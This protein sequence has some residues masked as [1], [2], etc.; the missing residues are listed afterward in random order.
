MTQADEWRNDDADGAGKQ[1]AV[2]EH[3][4]C[5]RQS[6]RCARYASSSS[7]VT[8]VSWSCAVI[9]VMLETG[10]LIVSLLSCIDSGEQSLIIRPTQS[11][12]IL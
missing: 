9:P 10:L 5:W 8:P 11:S 6:A 4:Q 1:T 2:E 7:Q 12:P 3:L